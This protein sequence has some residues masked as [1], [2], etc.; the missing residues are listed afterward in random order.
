MRR[1]VFLLLA[2]VLCSILVAHYCYVA[3]AKPEGDGFPPEVEKQIQDILKTKESS[4][5]A[6]KYR[7][8]FNKVG[9]KG[10][11]TL[12][13]Y[14][15][16]GIAIQAAW[17]EVTLTIPEKEPKRPDADKLKWFLE[18][19][20]RRGS[21]KAPRWWSEALL[22][23]DANRRDNIYPGEPKEKPY[24]RLGLDYTAGPLDS[25]LKRGRDT[26][27]LRIGEDSVPIPQGLLLKDD[28][29][30]LCCGVSG[31]ISHSRCFVAVHESVGYPYQLACIDRE[32]AKTLW[33]S[34]V[35]GTWW[36]SASGIHCMWVAVTEQNNRIVIFGSAATGM[37]MEAF[38]PEDGKNLFRFSTYYWR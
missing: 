32:T 23:S 4:K 18:F 2:P 11:R 6:Q 3:T 28:F 19:M 35:F 37:H 20:E 26:V 22:N 33:E 8:L 15:Q 30:K 27:E 5:V 25:S 29:G 7:T 1:S 24:H 21:V 16:E 36:G 31:L 9:P 10:I 17:E 34:Q 38:R 13:A 14:P 12:Q